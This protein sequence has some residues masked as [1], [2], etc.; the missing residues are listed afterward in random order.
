M[1]RTFNTT[2]FLGASVLLNAIIATAYLKQ[3]NQNR[4]Q[5]AYRVMG[6]E[7]PGIAADS[8]NPDLALVWYDKAKGF[9]IQYPDTADWIPAQL[10]LNLPKIHS[11]LWPQGFDH[12]LDETGSINSPMSFHQSGDT[13]R[14]DF[15]HD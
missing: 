4:N 10:G 9:C 8:S 6:D 2:F 7:S 11:I 14:V 15:A 13:L 3:N 5:E 12:V 1:K